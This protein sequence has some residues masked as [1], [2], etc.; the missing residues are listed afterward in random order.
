MLDW[1]R[2]ASRA[3]E[4]IIELREAWPSEGWEA[5]HSERRKLW[6]PEVERADWA[7]S[8]E[9]GETNWTKEL[10]FLSTLL[11]GWLGHHRSSPFNWAP[12]GLLG[13]LTFPF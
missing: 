8:W 1:T 3:S 9:R 4:W 11:S 5:W 10:P 13:L 7:E 12:L 6:H 2:A